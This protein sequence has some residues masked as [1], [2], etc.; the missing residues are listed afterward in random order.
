M[1]E[2]AVYNIATIVGLLGPAVSVVAILNIITPF[3]KVDNRPDPVKVE[4]EDNASILLEHESGAISH[5]QSGF[6]NFDPYGHYGS[7]KQ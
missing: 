6:N 5:I 3:R 2:L 7:K 1:P 4:E